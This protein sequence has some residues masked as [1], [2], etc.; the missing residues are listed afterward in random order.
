MFHGALICRILHHD[1]WLENPKLCNPGRAIRAG[2]HC[3]SPQE[4]P[5]GLTA[6]HC[7]WHN[8]DQCHRHFLLPPAGHG[9][10]QVCCIFPDLL[11]PITC[12]YYETITTKTDEIWVQ[13]INIVSLKTE[14]KIL[15]RFTKGK[16]LRRKQLDQMW[17][18]QLRKRKKNNDKTDSLLVLHFCSCDLY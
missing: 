12:F 5:P 17:A 8:N 18:W 6:A 3:D 9:A 10:G 2:M 15:G 16:S 1:R 11:I 13:K 14:L 4:Q 7:S